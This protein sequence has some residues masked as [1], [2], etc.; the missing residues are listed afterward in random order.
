MKRVGLFIGGIS[1]LV[2]ALGFALLLLGYLTNGSGTQVFDLPSLFFREPVSSGSVLIGLVHIVGF[3]TASFVCFAI[4]ALFF[5]HAM[6]PEEGSD[7]EPMRR[8]SINDRRQ[9][10]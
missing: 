3:A 9:L 10:L 1:G 7:V 5:A 2:C 8:L 4:G 6:I